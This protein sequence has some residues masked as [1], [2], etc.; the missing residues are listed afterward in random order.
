MTE[1]RVEEEDKAEEI[2]FIVNIEM[3]HHVAWETGSG[4]VVVMA[5][6]LFIEPYTLHRLQ[7]ALSSRSMSLLF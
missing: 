4:P 1:K 3:C 2:W 5:C 7:E 6:R